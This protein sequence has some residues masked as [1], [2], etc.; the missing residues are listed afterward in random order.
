MRTIV[1]ALALACAD[2]MNFQTSGASISITKAEKP[3]DNLPPRCRIDGVIDQRTGAGGK[4]Y[5]IGFA[6]ALPDN[7]NG[8]FLMQGGGGLN[9][10]VQ[11]PV[12]GQVSGDASA[13]A[14]GFAVV[15]TDTGHK[16]TG[17]VD[18]SFMEDQQAALDFYFSAIG[19]VTVVAKEMITRYY[20]RAANH[21][22][23]VG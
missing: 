2:M 7:W 1:M 3:A 6:L 12:G 4:A 18:G 19:R 15:S 9:G 23:Y 14:R 20:G 22:Y 10:S 13:L 16:G 8:R 21:S 11:N 17:A 5:G